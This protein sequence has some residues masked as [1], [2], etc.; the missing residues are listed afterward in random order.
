M[1][2]RRAVVA[3]AAGGAALTA[4]AG[5]A[6]AAPVVSRTLAKGLVTPWGLAFLPNGDAVV[7]S[8]ETG[9]VHRVRKGG[10]RSRIGTIECDGAA[11]GEGGL[12]GVALSPTFA[13]DRRA[14][15]YRTFGGVNQVVSLDYRRGA[16]SDLQVVLDG[17]PSAR[18][19]NGGGLGFGPDG[20]LYVS[21]GDAMVGPDAQSQTSLAGK[22]L[23]ITASGAV[24]DD[25]PFGNEVWTLGHRNVQGLAWDTT[26][27]MF[28]TE[29]GAHERDELNEIVAGDNY[30]WPVVEGGDGPG[31]DYHDPFVMWSPTRTCSPSGLTVARRRAWVASLRGECL[32]AVR[33]SGPDAGRKSRHFRGRFGR[34]RN[35]EAAPDGSLWLATSNTDQNGTPGRG[36][37]RIVRI[38]FR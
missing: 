11:D 24:P 34:V 6:D 28:A 31:G 3:G 18:V 29:Y 27:R 36:D 32:Y 4:L 7:T 12:L 22:I 33:L 23:R 16:L 35:V 20:H 1:I 15:F 9:E 5:R 2:S 38:V 30:G 21:T 14:Y 25:N 8:R 10:G 37:D 13:D 26:G 17:I 19:H